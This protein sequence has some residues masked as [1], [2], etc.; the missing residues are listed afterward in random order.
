MNILISTIKSW[1]I[2][3]FYRL[4]SKYPDINWFLVDKK[5]DLNIEKIKE[6]DPKYI[7]FPHWSWIVP[8]EIYDNYNAILFHMT[9]LP[10]GRGGSPLQNL[11]IREI[12][13]TKISAIKMERELDSGDIYLQRDFD[14]S[15][16]SAQ[17]IFI[18]MSD[19]I[20]FEMIPN[21]IENNIVPVPQ[22]GQ[23][24]T[25]KRRS[26]NDS[27]LL[28]MEIF[29]IRKVYDFIRMLDAEG[30]PKAFINLDNLKIKFSEIHLKNNKLIGRFE[31]E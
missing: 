13:Q 3:N 28:K 8:E 23:I 5:E 17:E 18:R 7:F 6:I 22:K 15:I 11:I 16:G 20:F 10:F 27:N 26:V 2:D 12:Y 9:D 25:F 29:T 4:K 19:I 30:Y 31:I 21:I 1:N 24:I 14:I